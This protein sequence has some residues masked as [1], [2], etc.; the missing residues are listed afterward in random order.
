[1]IEKTTGGKRLPKRGVVLL[2]TE[3]T[4]R[5]RSKAG[6]NWDDREMTPLTEASE[7]IEDLVG[8]KQHSCVQSVTHD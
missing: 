3:R 8:Q 4:G 1:M 7:I 2:E 5:Y 6:D